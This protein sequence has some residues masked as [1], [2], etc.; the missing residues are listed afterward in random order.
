MNEV[1]DSG[2]VCRVTPV[3]DIPPNW[4]REPWYF[5]T[6]NGSSNR[7]QVKLYTDEAAAKRASKYLRDDPRFQ[8]EIF[9]AK[10]VL[11]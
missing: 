4:A 7:R 2:F 3:G 10:L 9:K 6:A 1:I 11:E 8:V 5:T